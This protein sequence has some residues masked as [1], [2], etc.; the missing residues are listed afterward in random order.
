M[1]KTWKESD[2][3]WYGSAKVGNHYLFSA[4]GESSR[5]E[6]ELE[7]ILMAGRD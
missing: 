4:T 3:K 7:L 1:I 2:G 6:V 5:G